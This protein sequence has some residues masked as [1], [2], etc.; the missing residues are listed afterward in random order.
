M[1]NDDTNAPRT[2]EESYSSATSASHLR[3]EAHRTGAGDYIAAA[4]MSPYDTGM[5][6]MRL[7]S[8]WDRSAKPKPPTREAIEKLAA[9]LEIIPQGEPHAGM[10]AE[11][12]KG[13]VRY[14]KPIE[15]AERM[16]TAWHIHELGLLFQNL[17]TLPQVR[18]ELERW[19]GPPHA[20]HTV[21]SVLG[22]WLDPTC[23]TCNG[24]GVRLVKNSGGRSSGKPC[25]A[26]VMSPVPG[27]RPLP[28]AGLGRKLIDHIRACYGRAKADLKNGTQEHRSGQNIEQREQDKKHAQVAKLRRA[29]EEAKAE[30]A[31]DH[32]KIAQHFAQSLTKHKLRT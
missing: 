24:C 5:S 31:V 3:I 21:A 11:N 18:A 28:H 19:V 25:F 9:T 15:A 29:D 23:R 12:E 2:V 26:C 30:E 1:L 14:S 20:A 17:K 27:Q 7:R 4:G 10:V 16:A 6:L 22:W 13:K 32:L 8:E